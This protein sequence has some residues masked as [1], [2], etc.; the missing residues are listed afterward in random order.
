MREHL[1][2]E[3]CSHIAHLFMYAKQINFFSHKQF[4]SCN[5]NFESINFIE[6]PLHRNNSKKLDTYMYIVYGQFQIDNR[7]NRIPKINQNIN[8]KK[9]HT[10]Q[11]RLLGFFSPVRARKRERKRETALLIY[12]FRTLFNVAHKKKETLSKSL[13][14][15]VNTF[16]L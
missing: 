8:E 7:N 10:L 5:S 4:G 14:K 15:S 9:I 13:N 3:S 2:Q 12:I 16:Q 1:G 6:D 11:Y